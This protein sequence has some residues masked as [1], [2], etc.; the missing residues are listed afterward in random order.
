MEEK[1]YEKTWL[2]VVLLFVFFPVGLYALWKNTKIGKG[3]KVG[4][5]AVIV[6]AVLINLAGG[7]SGAGEKGIST[8]ADEARQEAAEAHV[9][10]KLGEVLHTQYFDFTVHSIR[11]QN[12]VNTGNMFIKLDPEPGN[13]YL[14][15][16]VTVKN[17]DT[18]SRMVQEGSVKIIYN[19]KEYE[20]DKSEH[21]LAD[22]WGFVM[23]QINPLTTKTVN[24][25]Y[26]IPAEI[27]GQAYWNPGRSGANDLIDLGVIK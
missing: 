1:W 16:R 4:G 3:W 14:V 2:V 19:N 18:E 27:Q 20:F 5:T 24:L 17:T 13:R 15:M 11:L 21:L 12:S 22:G 26:K 6:L 9:Y 7:G 8:G 23:D 10:P 25:V